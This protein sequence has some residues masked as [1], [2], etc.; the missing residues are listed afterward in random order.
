MA[1][2]TI[3]IDT[4]LARTGEARRA[5]AGFWSD[6]WWR[7]RHD[8][9]TI[10]ALAVFLVM[11]LLALG[12]DFL[13]DNFFHWNFAKQDL[14]N[15]YAKPTLSDP[16]MWLG[17]DHIGRSVVV[18]LLYGA[19]VSLFIG[20]FGMLVTLTIGIV[21]G[22]SAGYFRGWWDDVIVWL[23]STIRSIPTL[24]LLLIVGLL[25]RL[26]PLS[27]AVFLGV[28]GWTGIANLARGQTFALRERD[29]VVAARTI[30]ATPVRIMF[31]HI[32]PNLLPLMV[33]LATIDVASIILAESAISYIGFGIQPPTPSWGNMLN[34]ATQFVFRGP[35][36]IY[37]PGIAIAVTVLCLYLIGD[38]LRDALDPRLRGSIGGKSS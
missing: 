22:I 18:R 29:F 12:A 2:G 38:G 13:A 27:L 16:A 24:Y 36:L 23:V 17:G 7:L 10:A 28:L 26:D 11:V 35:H 30:G 32:F 3:A 25:F 6:A 19:R 34:N 4:R 33:V 5:S 20:V 8:P 31:R 14:L 37:G 21:V 1:Q 15:T 9:T